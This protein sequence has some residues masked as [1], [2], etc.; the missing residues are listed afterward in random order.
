MAPT[1]F[2]QHYRDHRYRL[3]CLKTAYT[4]LPLPWQ[5]GRTEIVQLD[6]PRHFQRELVSIYRFSAPRENENVK[7]Y[8]MEK[9]RYLCHEPFHQ[10]FL[11][12]FVN[13]IPPPFSQ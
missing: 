10:V 7:W 11:R 8:E 3:A 4:R 5:Q 6:V 12:A 1:N 13:S 2:D 9:Q